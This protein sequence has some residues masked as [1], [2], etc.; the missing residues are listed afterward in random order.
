MVTNCL[1]EMSRTVSVEYYIDRMLVLS[2][3]SFPN[4]SM[5]LFGL[6]IIKEKGS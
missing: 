4:S 2:I 5:S 6:K 3:L 1:I